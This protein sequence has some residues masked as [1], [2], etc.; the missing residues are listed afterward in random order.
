MAWFKVDD[1]FH[2][3]RKILSIPSRYRFAAIGLWT[4]AGSWSASELTDGHIPD[5][6]LK[7]WGAT[8]KTAQALVDAGLWTRTQGAYEFHAWLTYQPSKAHVEAERDASKARMR[9]MR[10]SRKKQEPLEQADTEGLFGRTNPN[11]YENVRN[12]DPTRP[13]QVSKDTSIDRQPKQINRPL[14]ADWTPTLEH[15]ERAHEYGLD[16][17]REAIKFRAHAEEKA[18]L[19]KNW[20]AAFTRWLTNAREYADRDNRTRTPNG[21]GFS[22]PSIDRQGDLLK[23]ERA[24][25]LEEMNQQPRLEINP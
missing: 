20:N 6:M 8:E 16:L 14:P 17:N 21:G 4:I 18:R 7:A 15:E 1:T 2:S 12:P 13:D 9:A 5:Y 25:I 23:Q 3:S 19:A 22:R 10:A 11:G 24:R